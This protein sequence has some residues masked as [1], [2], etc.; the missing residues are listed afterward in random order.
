ML[1]PGQQHFTLRL[2]SRDKVART[3]FWLSNLV[4]ILLLKQTTEEQMTEKRRVWIVNQ[5][6]ESGCLVGLHRFS[7]TNL[8][9]E[10]TEYDAVCI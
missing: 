1:A 3:Y 2:N 10:K 7:T 9:L 4:S 6:C 8:L 5:N